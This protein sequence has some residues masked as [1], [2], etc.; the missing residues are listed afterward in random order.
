MLD[1]QTRYFLGTRYVRD[2]KMMWSAMCLVISHSHLENGARRQIR[3]D[4]QA[5]PTTERMRLS[6]IQCALGIPISRIVADILSEYF[7]FH[8]VVVHSAALMPISN[9]LSNNF[10]GA[11][12][13]GRLDFNLSL[14]KYCDHE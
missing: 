13:N 9:R 10:R 2:C 3:L 4:R 6:L 12:T 1:H 5:R 8:Y 11:G 14:L 7:M